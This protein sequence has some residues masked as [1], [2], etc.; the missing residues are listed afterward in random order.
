MSNQLAA[1]KA[2]MI[3]IAIA[4]IAI[5][6]YSAPTPPE[7]TVPNPSTSQLGEAVIPTCPKDQPFPFP[8]KECGIGGKPGL[9]PQ[10]L[11]ILEADLNNRVYLNRRL[12]E[13]D[14]ILLPLIQI[15]F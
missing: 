9:D 8:S 5:P 1:F 4:A 6:A 11:E 7:V 10:E 12:I 3:G 14:K 2:L 13:S 15:I